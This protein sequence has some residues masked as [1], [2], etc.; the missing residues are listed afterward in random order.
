MQSI[1][2]QVQ[3]KKYVNK[4]GEQQ[5]KTYIYKRVYNR[6][7]NKFDEL[8]NKYSSIICGSDTHLI[9]FNNLLSA[10]D[11]EDKKKYTVNQL[12]NFIYRN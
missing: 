7:G 12:R 11:Q 10:L 1:H 8:K 2:Q 4:N 3:I 9:K 6:K 5:I